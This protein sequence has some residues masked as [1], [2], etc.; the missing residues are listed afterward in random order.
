MFCASCG[1]AVPPGLSYCNRCGAD[2]RAKEQS[3]I[4]SSEASPDSLTWAIVAVTVVGLGA[5]IA[6][7]TIMKEVLH[8]NDGL[9]IGFSLLTFLSFLVVD[10][11]FIWK[12]LRS[13]RDAKEAGDISQLKE[14]TRREFRP[15]P[16]ASLPEPVPSVIDHTTRTLEPVESSRQAGGREQ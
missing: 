12:F 10:A 3:V 8:F 11:V 15:A 13:M 4:K 2:L 6:L 7:M 16:A 5:V 9:I 14:A 1:S